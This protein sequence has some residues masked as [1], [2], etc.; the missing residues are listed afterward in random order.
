MN[1]MTPVRQDPPPSATGGWSLVG[2]AGEL[3]RI[4]TSIRRRDGPAGVVLIGAAGV[5]KTRLAR[6]ALAAAEQ[7]GAL[8]RWVAG[9]ASA[10]ALPLG[11]FAA[12]LKLADLDPARLVPQATEALLA[13][14]GP[15]GVVVV[16]DDAHLLDELSAVLVHQ[17][18][19]RKAAGVVL[20]LRTGH[21]AQDA[22]TALWK[23]GHLPR[24]ELE[25]LSPEE[26]AEL[27]E[28]RLGGPVDDTAVR[29]LWSITRG[30]ALYLRQL[31]DHELA[32]GRLREFVGVWRW[33]GELT[34]SPALVELVSTRIGDLPAHQRGVLDVLAFGGPLEVPLLTELTGAHAMEETEARGLIE[35][36]PQ[37]RRWVVRLADPM[38]GEVQRRRT[39]ALYARRLRRR[40]ADAL[41]AAGG[42]RADDALRHA[43]LLLDADANPNATLLTV[44]AR[45]AT[46][47]GDL[48]LAERLA[49]TAVSAGGGFEPR[50]LLGSALGWTGRVAEAG[51]EW[52]TLPAL[53]GTDVQRAQAA[54]ARAKVLAWSG[55]PAEAEAELDA[56]VRAATDEA[57]DLALAGV[58][59]VLDAYLGRTAQA[60]RIGAEVL[61]HP[62]CPAAAVPW[63]SWGLAMA[64]G[65]LGRLDEVEAALRRMESA[66]PGAGLH[67]WALVVMS[68]M[69]G[70]L[71]AGLP[72]QADRIER[73]FRDRCPDSPGR[74]VDVFTSFMAAE[75]AA[76]RGQVGTAARGY[77]QAI[78]AHHGG[79]PNGWSFTGLVGLTTALGMHGD[80]AR[81]R[82][83]LTAMTAEHHPTY[84]FLAP[85]VLLARAWVAAAE[86]GVSE[87][88]ALTRKAADVA[89]SQ[90]QPAVEVLALH[91][92]VRFGDRTVTGRLARLATEVTGPRARIAAEHARALAAGDGPGLQAVSVR[93]EQMGALLL[94]V[95]A[96]AQA[97]AAHTH[98]GRRGSAQTATARARRLAE[99][100]EGARTPALAALTA[101]PKLT[102]RQ[103]EI[104]TLAAS[105][106]SNGDIAERLVVSVRTVENHLYRASA[107]PGTSPG[108]QDRPAP[109]LPG[110]QPLERF[111]GRRQREQFGL[112]PDGAGAGQGDHLGQFPAA[113][114]ERE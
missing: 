100:C 35:V 25:P 15:A 23:D 106:L 96:A 102:R 34:L 44:A 22:V 109:D 69:R 7:R 89:A 31:V 77:R 114:P 24:L 29:R 101:P 68:A 91:T 17:L 45:R 85:N 75:S 48:A 43:V 63:A 88:T 41:S 99:A 73:R 72:D 12:T 84:V 60:A 47:R 74:P 93:F 32:T 40:I 113:A 71:L 19:L 62:R 37:G 82:R 28:T 95:D 36:S 54:M 66:A 30:N 49:R 51:S 55:R 18:V 42:R 52:A 108:Q 79:D 1:G 67:Q 2:R 97:A 57:A 33:S 83:A 61:A 56:A 94:A 92:A 6:E 90:R 9:T 53:A 38:F 65:G 39:G 70:L 76:F 78:A 105:G 110:A 111:A 27:V 3:D 59:S 50:L 20:T 8:A 46:E 103:R 5:G 81:A 58:R 21:A 107:R 87:A 80:P 10:R 14:A 26:T 11:A 4:A 64:H 98:H 104:L 16:V 112:H 13:G 86:G